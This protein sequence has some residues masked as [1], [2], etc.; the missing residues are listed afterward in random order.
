MDGSASSGS[1]WRKAF[2]FVEARRVFVA[3]VALER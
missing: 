2:D 1:W 3:V